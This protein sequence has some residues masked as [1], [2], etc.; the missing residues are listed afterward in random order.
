MP[1]CERSAA[2]S[3]WRKHRCFPVADEVAGGVM[4]TTAKT[5]HVTE[6][7]GHGHAKEPST[8]GAG[9]ATAQ[10]RLLIVED[11]EPARRQLQKLLQAD[12]ELQVDVCG[13]GDHALR[14]LTEN[15]YSLL[16]TD[17]RMPKLDGMELIEEI[18]RRRLPVTV[19]VTTG[20][21]SIE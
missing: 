15:S 8:N 9:A 13:D 4:T 19:I 5:H 2:Q 20:E 17:L 10:R 14:L 7:H 12:P 1:T 16:I 21:G 6:S 11:D 3:Q 18:Q